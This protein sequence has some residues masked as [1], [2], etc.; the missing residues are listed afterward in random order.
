MSRLKTAKKASLP[1]L[2]GLFA[3]SP[4][5]GGETAALREQDF[6]QTWAWSA[7]VIVP[8]VMLLAVYLRGVVRSVRLKRPVGGWRSCA[9]LMGILLIFLALQSPLVP[10]AARSF[11]LHQIQLFLLRMAGPMLVMLSQPAGALMAGLPRTMRRR[12]WHFFVRSAAWRW[13]RRATRNP[14]VVFVLF[15]APLGFWQLP[16]IHDAALHNGLLR[17]L[18]HTGFLG[19][20]LLFFWRVF[21]RATPPEGFR[22]GVRMMMLI[23]QSL[24]SIALGVMITL[25]KMVLYTAYDVPGRLFAQSPLQDEQA[26]GFIIWIS[27]PMMALVAFAFVVFAWNRHERQR[28]E[29]RFAHPRSN[30]AML[31]FPETAEELWIKV[32]K[33]NRETALSLALLPASIFFLIIVLAIMAHTAG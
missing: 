30:S 2:A 17:V 33:P 4:V 14:I 13:P 32:E 15:M 26:G 27:A 1:W 5:W 10:F 18:M 31:E 16:A 19:F 23:G 7:A 6:W 12:L 9:F 3:A 11:W 25:K 22:F 28:F 24:L 20:G 8:T 29:N 21:E